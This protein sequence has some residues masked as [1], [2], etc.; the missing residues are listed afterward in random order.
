[1]LIVAVNM[2]ERKKL[3]LKE[4][5]DLWESRET[6]CVVE[7]YRHRKE[8]RVNTKRLEST[9]FGEYVPQVESEDRSSWK[10]EKPKHK[11]RKHFKQ[12]CE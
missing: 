12:Q 3:N 4:A 11:E 7:G 9:L 10:E 2:S 8:K 6:W 1:M 5:V